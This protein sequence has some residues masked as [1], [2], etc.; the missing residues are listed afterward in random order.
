MYK[1]CLR[2]YFWL[3]MDIFGEVIFKYRYVT[4]A[5]AISAILAFI[6]TYYFTQ[7]AEASAA[8]LDRSSKIP[9][10]QRLYF[11]T[12]VSFLSLCLRHVPLA[13]F[14]YLLQL[15]SR[16]KFVENLRSYMSLPYTRFHKK[17]PGEIRFTVFLKALSYPICAQIVIFDFT[18]LIGSTLFTF[19]KAYSDLNIYA[20]V[21]FSL[22]PICYF[23]YMLVFLKYKIIY[24]T[25][26]LAEQEKTSSQIYDKFSNYDVIKTYNLEE[27]EIES[28]RESLKSQAETQILLD[29][30]T[31]KG[32]YL[33]RFINISPYVLLA[34]FSLLYPASMGGSLFFQATL[35]YSSLSIQIRKLGT[36]LAKLASYLNQI[37]Y[38]TVSADNTEHPT[39]AVECFQDRIEYIN[40]NL[41][42]E[43]KLVVGKINCSIMKGEKIAIVGKNGTGKSTFIKSLLG[44]THYTGDIL[45]DGTDARNLSGKSVLSLISYIPQEDY[46]SD[47]TVLNNLRLGNRNATRELIESKARLFDSH[48]TFLSLENGYDTKAGIRG[49][50]LSGGQKQKISLVRAAVKDAPIFVLDEATAAIDKGYEA[51]AL[52]II[53]RKM[54]EKTVVMII[55][56][57]DRLQEFDR[58]FFL[59]NGRLE[60]TGR[61]EE[62]VACSESFR[63]FVSI[64]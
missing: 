27:S 29:I 61:Y 21:V 46:T 17:T 52:E 31:A 6:S 40:V 49:N 56:E 19:L 25:L 26:N 47:D 30:F 28:L 9:F 7:I 33:I 44:F 38:D 34:V 32:K 3:F 4:I 48:E 41:Y 36:Q 59:N 58:V 2:E 54:P 22:F 20:A 1:P 11:F 24:H 42:H 12:K 55:H 37:R 23:G 5:A 16:N 10:D 18:S 8:L 53:L 14:T 63:R 50:R 62:L 43:E 64:E 35:L 57:K 45:I 13:F 60:D 15:I 39:R 51:R